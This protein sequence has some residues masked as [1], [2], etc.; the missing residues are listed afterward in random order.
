MSD[1]RWAAVIII[2]AILFIVALAVS[3]VVS[4]RN[5]CAE[6]QEVTGRETQLRD[7]VCLIEIA[8]GLFVEELEV[9]YYLDHVEPVRG[10]E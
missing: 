7:S 6:L 4:D 1:E 3:G 9:V 2:G 5:A 10:G 8:P